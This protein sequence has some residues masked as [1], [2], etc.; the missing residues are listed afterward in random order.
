MGIAQLPRPL[1]GSNAIAEQGELQSDARANSN[2]MCQQHRRIRVKASGRHL[3]QPGS[4]WGIPSETLQISFISG[5]IHCLKWQG[6][7]ARSGIG[8]LGRRRSG[9]S[10]SASFFFGNGISSM[11]KRGSSIIGQVRNC[12]VLI[13]VASPASAT[14]NNAVVENQVDHTDRFTFQIKRPWYDAIPRT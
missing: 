9:F 13:L 14:E 4:F 8:R 10:G 7:F 5:R 3:R 1:K 11:I 12:L 6:A 2:Q